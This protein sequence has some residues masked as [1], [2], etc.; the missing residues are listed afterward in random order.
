MLAHSFN[1]A[2]NANDRTKRTNSN[3]SNNEISILFSIVIGILS[4]Q[5]RFSFI[6]INECPVVPAALLSEEKNQ[7]RQMPWI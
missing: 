6:L 5:N 4:D 7:I 1:F 2:V 3:N